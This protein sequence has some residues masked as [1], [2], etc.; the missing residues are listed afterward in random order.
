MRSPAS[1]FSLRTSD[2]TDLQK[3]T[4]LSPTPKRDMTRIIPSVREGKRR[5]F[6]AAVTDLGMLLNNKWKLDMD[7]IIHVIF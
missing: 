4:S 6:T 2:A 1:V 3:V 5:V 7:Q